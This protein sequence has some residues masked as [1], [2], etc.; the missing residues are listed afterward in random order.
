MDLIGNA[1]E[2][3]SDWY[4]TY[5]PQDQTDPTGPRTGHRR[6]VRGSAFPLTAK[7]WSRAAMRGPQ[8]RDTS[9]EWIG[10][11]VVRELTADERKYHELKERGK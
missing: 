5:Q 6:I 10:F 3:V 9:A 7:L 11:R 8:A 1:A 4:G 2:W